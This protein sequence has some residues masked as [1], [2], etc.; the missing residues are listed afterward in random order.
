MR[1]VIDTN[2]LLSGLFWHGAPHA[3]LA[4]ARTG[5]LTLISSPALI[6]ELSETISRKRFRDILIR[7]GTDS[8]R[9]LAEIS[10]LIELVDP[11]PLL[12]PISR[13]PDDDAVLAL[14]IAARCDLVISGDQDLLVLGHYADIPIVTPA[15]ALAMIRV[16]PE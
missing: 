11:A 14:A 10:L 5:T 2:V 6:A 4:Q 12:K 9:I 1:A 3:L 8:G 16:N 13:D 7:T 15:K